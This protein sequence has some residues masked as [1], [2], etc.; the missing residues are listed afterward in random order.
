MELLDLT[1]AVR[2]CLA[3]AAAFEGP[4]RLIQKLLFPGIN[5]I[6]MNLIALGQ[7]GHRS[8]LPKRLQ[9][10]LRL[11]RRVDLPSRPLRHLPLR[12]LRRHGAKSNQSTDPKIR[13]PLHCLLINT[14]MR[15]FQCHI[16]H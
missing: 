3:A 11:Q 8:P 9:R 12:L 5:L 14:A 16:Y 4:R 1:L 6:G 2:R 10:N 7:I 15:Y 13:G